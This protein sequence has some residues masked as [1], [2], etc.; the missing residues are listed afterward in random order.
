[1]QRGVDESSAG[2]L[3]QTNQEKTMPMEKTRREFLR[4]SAVGS[5]AT[6]TARV[7]LAFGMDPAGQGAEIVARGYEKIRMERTCWW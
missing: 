2:T 7:L 6:A 4:S 5:A 1:M 3:L